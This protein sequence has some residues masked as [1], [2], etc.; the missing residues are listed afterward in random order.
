[1]YTA[2]PSRRATFEIRVFGIRV[3]E[4]GV[5]EMGVSR[6]DVSQPRGAGEMCID[7]VGSLSSDGVYALVV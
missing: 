1:M 5:F 3:F 7:L 6:M 2:A 4:I